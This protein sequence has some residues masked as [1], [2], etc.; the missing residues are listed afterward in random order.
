MRAIILAVLVQAGRTELSNNP[1]DQSL[2]PLASNGTEWV[3]RLVMA[4]QENNAFFVGQTPGHLFFPSAGMA[5]LPVPGG[6]GLFLPLSPHIFAMTVPKIAA[7]GVFDEV[8]KTD[9]MPSALS[10]GIAGDRVVIP[11]TIEDP[12]WTVLAAEIRKLRSIANRYCEGHMQDVA[13]RLA[14]QP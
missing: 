1:S 2:D 3:D 6:L 4:C 9:G 12:D 11:P 14:R 10:I 7:D 13:D 8:M 5:P